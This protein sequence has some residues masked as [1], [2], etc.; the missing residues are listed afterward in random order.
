VRRWLEQELAGVSN[1]G[2]MHPR[3]AELVRLLRARTG[4]LGDTSLAALARHARLSP[5]RFAHVFTASVGI[6]LRRYL[7]WLRVQ[8]A[9]LALTSG[10]TA[11]EAAYL[12]GF[13]DAAHLSRTFR[14]MFGC[15]PR[16]IVRRR[17][18]VRQLR[19]D[20]AHR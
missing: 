2:A 1:P 3:V 8:R 13:S 20:E 15:P 12:A 10:C 11:T 7:L 17:K 18:D 4:D 5:S 14:R 19:V 16:E 6:P 9:A